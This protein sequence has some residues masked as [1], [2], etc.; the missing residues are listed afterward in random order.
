MRQKLRTITNFSTA[1]S[2]TNLHH[3]WLHI[4]EAS[5]C[6]NQCVKSS[7]YIVDF[8]LD[9]IFTV[10]QAANTMAS[11]WKGQDLKIGKRIVKVMAIS[12]LVKVL[13]NQSAKE[14]RKGS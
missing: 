8:I 10:S 4:F 1:R 7:R 13:P 6:Y 14:Y 5:D 3:F 12:Q 11:S 9:G 2:W